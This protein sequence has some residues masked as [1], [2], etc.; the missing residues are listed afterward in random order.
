[1]IDFFNSILFKQLNFNQHWLY[2][3]LI[4]LDSQNN[5]D[6]S[7]SHS[8]YLPSE[9]SSEED[10]EYVPDDTSVNKIS[11]NSNS[12]NNSVNSGLNINN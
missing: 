2:N 12:F 10:D 1:M 5:D 8:D 6:I 9:H 11:R 7:D 4:V 3:I